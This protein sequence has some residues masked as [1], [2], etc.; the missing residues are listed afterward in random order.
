M[1]GAPRQG[2]CEE[3]LPPASPLS[4][5]SA[6]GVKS[7][8]NPPMAPAHRCVG[9]RAPAQELNDAHGGPAR[10]PTSKPDSWARPDTRPSRTDTP[11]SA[12]SKESQEAGALSAL[13]VGY[14]QG[15]S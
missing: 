3:G 4:A 1:R 15:S 13:G 9:T 10:S 2:S 5:L 6:S 7:R 11:G 14:F 12:S 8:K